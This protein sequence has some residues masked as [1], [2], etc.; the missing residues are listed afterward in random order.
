[1]TKTCAVAGCKT[2]CKKQENGVK[3]ISNPGTVIGFP[4]E[5]KPSTLLPE[6]IRFCN[7][8][9]IHI[10]EHVGICTKHFD[11]KFVKEG[12]R[13]TLRWELH[14]IP[15]KYCPDIEV[16]PSLMPT[17]PT[18]RKLPTD[19]SQPDQLNAF[20]KEDLVQSL[21]DVTDSLCPPGYKLEVHDGKAAILYKL[22]MTESNIP[23]VTE[24]IVIDQELHVKLYKRSIPIPLP[25]W[26]R[27]GGDC[28]VK[29]KSVIENFPNYIKNY[30]DVDIPD[31]R[32]IPS[33][34]MDELHKLKYKKTVNDGPKYSP[35]MI[36]YALLMYYT[37]PQT[38][39]MLLETLPF[40]SISLLKKLSQGGIEPLKACKL[41]L[42]RGKMDRDVILSL[43][44]IYIQKDAGYNGGRITGADA[45]GKMFK[46]V[47]AFMINGLQ[48]AVPFVVKAIP[49]LKITGKWI[50]EHL[51]ELIKSLHECGFFVRAV[52]SDNH[53]TNVSAFN[54]ML[55]KYGSKDSPN[56][57]KH[58]SRDG[59]IYLFYDSV[60]LLKNVR[61]NLLNARRF[62]FPSFSFHEFYD[63]I[64]VPEG[65]ITWKQL[66]D[67][68][69][70][71]QLLDGYLRKAPKLSYKSKIPN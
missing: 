5:S 57:I 32:N 68:Y 47:V 15:T 34:I 67:V 71:D 6:W 69:D 61:N 23:E 31:S 62:N 41:L 18:H 44:E 33:D 52:I 38:Y 46:G 43:D 48:N 7:Q 50:A 26:F 37:S 20:R 24:T 66:H 17:T 58:P 49:E 59:K 42:E 39:K 27:K 25:Q 9:S 53:S 3:I 40:P 2:N 45:D 21:A 54:F 19:R 28:R 11:D 1:M 56:T 14:P 51:D 12:K 36:R 70:R 29:H 60:H 4:D 63:D 8:K 55:K 35:R 30:G 65:K 22:E 64:D 16:P 10:T 13:K